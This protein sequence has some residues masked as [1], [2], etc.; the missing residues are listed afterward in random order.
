MDKAQKHPVITGRPLDDC[1]E[2]GNLMETYSM[3]LLAWTEDCQ[4][5]MEVGDIFEK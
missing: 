4:M 2:V 3:P 1:E 5:D